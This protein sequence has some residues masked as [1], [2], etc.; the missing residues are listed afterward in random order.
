MYTWRPPRRTLTTA[1][2]SKQSGG[3]MGSLGICSALLA[4]LGL[5]RCFWSSL[6]HMQATYD[7]CLPRG[8]APR[9]KARLRE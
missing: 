7:A 2:T 9:G 1:G 3:H 4:C 5:H 8:K 6:R